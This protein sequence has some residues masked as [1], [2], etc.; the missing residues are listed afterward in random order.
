MLVLITIFIGIGAYVYNLYSTVGFGE[1]TFIE[2]VY[3]NDISFAGMTK[4]EGVAKVRTMEDEWLNESFTLTYLDKSWTFSRTMVNAD[5]DYESR[6]EM[7]WNFGHIGNIFDRK[8]DIEMFAKNPIRLTADLSYDE[9]L[10]DSFV[11]E[12]C[13]AIYVA[14]VDAVVER[15][16]SVQFSHSVL[17]DSATP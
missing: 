2:N 17:S 3:V 5:I 11:D 10:L 12:I 9:A 15:F 14:P 7:A 16:S 4:E 8:R 1:P 13:N 6:M